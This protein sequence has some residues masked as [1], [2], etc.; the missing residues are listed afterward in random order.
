MALGDIQYT[1]GST[2]RNVTC[3]CCGTTAK[4]SETVTVDGKTFCKDSAACCWRL[5]GKGVEVDYYPTVA[6][7]Q[8]PLFGD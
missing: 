4:A 1:Y 5:Q 6:A 8:K 2:D 7:A 3:Q